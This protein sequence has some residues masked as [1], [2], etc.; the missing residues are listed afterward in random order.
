M[1]KALIVVDMQ[2]DFISGSLGS[3]HAQAIV[4]NVCRKIENFDGEIF[5][6]RDTH[7]Q[8]NYM[9]TTE[10]KNLPVMHCIKDTHGWQVED[11]V[12]RA[13]HA[14]F[15]DEVSFA[16]HGVDKCCFGSPLLAAKIVAAG[17]SFVELV[18][19][20]TDV[21]VISN[22]VLLR[23]QH[24]NMCVTVDA[25]CCAGVTFESHAT[26]LAAMKSCGIHVIG[27]AH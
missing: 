25:A 22:A 9:E 13:L 10:G 8:T 14:K 5:Y 24:P 17:I 18:G 2:N 6:T 3:A 27:E 1:K 19:L 11:S 26:A 16:A 12:Y 20:C 15:A 7:E 21:C 23:N 4:G